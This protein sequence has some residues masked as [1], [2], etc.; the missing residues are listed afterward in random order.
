MTSHTMCLALR[1]ASRPDV[2]PV[3]PDSA[4]R[5]QIRVTITAKDMEF[6][7]KSY[8]QAHSK[9]PVSAHRFS[10]I[11]LLLSR[12]WIR[13]YFYF[14]VFWVSIVFSMLALMRAPSARK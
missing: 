7:G 13:T 5:D 8:S 9:A 12:P 11:A 3:P 4:V 1:L 14:L 6:D 10:V 2:D